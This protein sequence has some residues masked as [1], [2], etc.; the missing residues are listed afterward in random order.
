[1]TVTGYIH[2]STQFQKL[3]ACNFIEKDTLAQMFFC[4]FCEILRTPFLQNTSRWL[5]Q[6]AIGFLTMPGDIE[7]K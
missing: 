2:E 3:E 1:M 6:K 5:F 7:V 4:E